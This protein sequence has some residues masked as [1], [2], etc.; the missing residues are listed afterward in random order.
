[1]TECVPLF[2]HSIALSPLSPRAR[3]MTGVTV[4]PRGVFVTVVTSRTGHRKNLMC[5]SFSTTVSPGHACEVTTVTA[6][7][8]E[9]RRS[10][11]TSGTRRRP[12]PDE[13]RYCLPI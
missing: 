4:P 6:L 1:M 3:E 8:G 7:P 9:V 12:H 5:F 10:S 13:A 11:G 2:Q